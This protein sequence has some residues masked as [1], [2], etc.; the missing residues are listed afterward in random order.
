MKQ[1]IVLNFVQSLCV[2]VLWIDMDEC[3]SNKHTENYNIIDFGYTTDIY[4]Y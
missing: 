1:E 3:T 4:G 2:F